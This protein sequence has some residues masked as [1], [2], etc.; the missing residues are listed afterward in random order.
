MQKWQFAQRQQ[1]PL[2]AK[3]IISNN[4]IKQWYEHWEG[5]VYVSVSGL[6]SQVLLHIVRQIYPEVI[7]VYN[8]TG[9]EFPEVRES[10]KNLANI[11]VI[12][13]KKDFKTVIKEYGYPVISKEQSQYIHEVRSTKSEALKKIRLEGRDGRYKI[14]EKWKYLIDAPFKI[15]HKCCHW[16]KKKPF[17]DFEKETGLK[18]MLGILAEE[19]RLRMNSVLRHSCNAFNLKR[20]Q[21]RSLAHWSKEDVWEY[22]KMYKVPYPKVY[23]MGWTQTGCMFCLYGIHLEKEPNRFQR[24]KQTHPQIYNYCMEKLGLKEVLNYIKVNY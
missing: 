3:L 4:L 10:I 24:M 16:L 7:G 2:E 5:K 20:P 6:D 22:Q 15:S 11:V 14:S 12:K 19:S 23:D 1:L 13:P 17:N 18:P 21:S 8:D 9:L